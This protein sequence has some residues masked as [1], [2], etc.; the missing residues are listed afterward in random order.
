MVGAGCPPGRNRRRYCDSHHLRVKDCTVRGITA[1]RL[2][3]SS[4]L[5][6][7]LVA[8]L[9]RAWHPRASLA[10]QTD[11]PLAAPMRQAASGQA[12]DLRT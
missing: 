10:P 4:D 6:K 7:V 5:R 12:C 11:P 8:S 2:H 9:P 1:C 3:Q